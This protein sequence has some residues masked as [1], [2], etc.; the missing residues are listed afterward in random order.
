MGL[1]LAHWNDCYT[2]NQTMINQI[3]YTCEASYW[4]LLNFAALLAYFTQRR[5]VIYLTK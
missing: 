4:L 1:L 2:L 3:N 5:K